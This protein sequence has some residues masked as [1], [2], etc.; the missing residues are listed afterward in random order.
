M[1]SSAEFSRKLET[2]IRRFVSPT[3]IPDVMQNARIRL[4]RKYHTLSLPPGLV[5]ASMQNEAK[6]FRRGKSRRSKRVALAEDLDPT[7]LSNAADENAATT[8]GDDEI[9]QHFIQAA[10][11]RLPPVERLLLVARHFENL[12]YDEIAAKAGISVG[13]VKTKLDRA[14]KNLSRELAPYRAELLDQS[15]S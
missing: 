14:N 8:N 6:N 4:W 11:G 1:S 7:L 3:E 15:H 12:S 13:T 2:M 5:Y 9:F 10:L